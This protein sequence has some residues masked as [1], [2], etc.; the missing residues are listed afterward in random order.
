MGFLLSLLVKKCWQETSAGLWRP[1]TCSLNSYTSDGLNVCSCVLNCS[2]FRKVLL[3]GF[4][5]LL[6]DKGSQAI[7]IFS[8]QQ[9]NWGKK[10][11]HL[12]DGDAQL[13]NRRYSMY[14]STP[15]STEIGCKMSLRHVL[16]NLQPT[17]CHLTLSSPFHS[18]KTWSKTEVFQ[19][20]LRQKRILFG[21]SDCQDKAR[22]RSWFQINSLQLLLPAPSFQPKEAIPL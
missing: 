6:I 7:Y 22:E 2:C 8:R 15:C 16:K 13:R 20:N 18:W 11:G 21:I 17:T 12:K 3:F 19:S 14:C 10:T 9:F 1:V 4:S 5:W